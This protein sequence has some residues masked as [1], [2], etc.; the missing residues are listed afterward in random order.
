MCTGT[1]TQKLYDSPGCES[2]V[3][4]NLLMNR[5]STVLD[6]RKSG[7]RVKPEV[8]KE[9]RAR[10]MGKLEW[11]SQKKGEVVDG[12]PLR[13]R[14]KNLGRFIVGTTDH[15]KADSRWTTC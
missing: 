6:A 8:F 15:L 11:R 3:G 10:F 2:S 5:F 9:D 13:I 14:P 7:L 1:M 4:S 12:E